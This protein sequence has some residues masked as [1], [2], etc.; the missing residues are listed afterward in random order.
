MTVTYEQAREALA[1]RLTPSAV[2][3]SERVA[4]TAISLAALYGVN[5][6]EA[7]LAGLLH[8]WDRE[9]PA[10]ELVALAR[11]LGLDVTEVDEAVPYLLHGP[12]AEAG[13]AKAF[14][15]LS[16]DVL[17]AVGAHTYGVPK[18]TPLAMVVYIADVIEPSREQSGVEALRSAAGVRPLEELFAEAYAGSLR[19]L[20]DSR[21]RLHPQTVATWN[22]IVAETSR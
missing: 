13:L 11:E 8:D 18:M 15:D 21:R 22:A 3:H 9:T 4:A 6:A 17:G 5:E 2:D 16:R 1:Q 7:G 10:E 14:P 20:V 12:V 19:H